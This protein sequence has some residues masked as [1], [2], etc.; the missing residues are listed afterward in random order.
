MSMKPLLF[1]TGALTAVVEDAERSFPFECCGFLFGLITP[2]HRHIEEILVVHNQVEANAARR[3]AIAPADYMRAERHALATGLTLL[4]IYH[5]HPSHPA[6][7]SIHD[8][9]VA[10]PMFS[11]VIASVHAEGLVGLR[12]WQL[13]VDSIFSEEPILNFIPTPWLHY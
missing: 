3:F 1:Q 2:A 5:S 4:G 7:P 12:S 11:Y 8:L 6:V 13:N 10:L 9:R